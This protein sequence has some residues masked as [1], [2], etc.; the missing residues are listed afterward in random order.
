MPAIIPG[1]STYKLQPS[2]T[3]HSSSPWAFLCLVVYQM[4]LWAV[5]LLSLWGC[6][7]NS[8]L[9]RQTS[10]SVGLCIKWPSEQTDFFLCGVVYQ[11]VL[12]AIRLLFLWG[13]VYHLIHNPTEKE[14]W[15]LRG[16]FDTQSHRERSLIAQR[17]IWYTTKRAIRLLSLFGCVSNGPLSC[18]TSFSVGLCIK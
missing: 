13:C 4:V 14:V 1:R 5:R 7:S 2:S 10:F 8:P 3:S 15:P 18:Q 9:S 16:P 17:T 12:W 11:M 6:V